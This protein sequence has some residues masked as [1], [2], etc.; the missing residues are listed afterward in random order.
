MYSHCHKINSELVLYDPKW[1]NFAILT[2]KNSNID[3]KILND[4]IV[5]GKEEMI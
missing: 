5:V 4:F 2:L 3:L 1:F